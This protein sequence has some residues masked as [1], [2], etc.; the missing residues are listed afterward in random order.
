MLCD[1]CGKNPASIKMVIVVAGERRE[2]NLCPACAA[3]RRIP[4]KSIGMGQLL[5]AVLDAPRQEKETETTVC[6]ACGTKLSQILRTQRVGCAQCYEQFRAQIGALLKK[7][8]GADTHIGRQNERGK[9]DEES[10][11]S[12]LRQELEMAV[13]CENF[14]EAAA[15]R[16]AIHA[17]SVP[18][19]E[20]EADG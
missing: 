1:E 16:D 10:A 9:K 12:R 17:L 15:L 11:L 8:Q 7:A 6:P 18:G 2:L 5:A 14:E 20:D 13:A 3:K 4:P 19:G